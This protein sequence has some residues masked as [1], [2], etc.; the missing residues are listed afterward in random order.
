MTPICR[1]R[2]TGV[3]PFLSVREIRWLGLL[4]KRTVAFLLVRCRVE[5][6]WFGLPRLTL[7]A[8]DEAGAYPVYNAAD[9]SVND[10][11][12][13]IGS[14]NLRLNIDQLPYVSLL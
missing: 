13:T 12:F 4:Y 9:L 11:L 10:I 1:D 3:K 7:D 5:I 2:A 14:F 6:R 8:P